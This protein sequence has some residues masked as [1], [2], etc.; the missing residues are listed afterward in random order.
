MR[1]QTWNQNQIS[2]KLILILFAFFSGCSPGSPTLIFSANPTQITRPTSVTPA[3]Q[4]TNPPLESSLTSVNSRNISLDSIHMIDDKQGWAFSQTS[5]LKTWDSGEDWL[6]ITPAEIQTILSTIP[7]QG[8]ST[9][10]IKGSFLSDQNAW[11]AVPGLNQ[12]TIFHTLDG[13]Q[14]WR[15]AKLAVSTPQ[16]I[17][18]IQISSFTFL[19]PQTG[20]LLTSTGMATGHE[21]VELYKTQNGGTTWDF[22]AQ[23]NQNASGESIGSITTI[24]QKTG[25]SFRDPMDGWLTGSTV[26]NVIFFYRTKDS[27]LTWDPQ[28]LFIPNGYTALGGSSSSYP[29]VFFN[30]KVGSL[31]VYLGKATPSINLFFYITI[32][33]GESWTP[34]APLVSQSNSFVWDW[35]DPSHG[36]A[37]IDGS[38]TITITTDGGKSWSEVLVNGAKFHQLDFVSPMIGWA[39]SDK[40]LLQTLDGGEN[41]HTI[42]P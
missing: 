9:F 11:I 33:A 13:G 1:T 24:G 27:G 7:A 23:A 38:N 19:N 16:E 14:T 34:I 15:D 18:P 6:N 10:E 26:G 40:S 35:V 31:P 8:V 12:I 28:Q 29:P 4:R 37:T 17:Y 25:I 30:S 41:W 39:I 32:D 3:T 20:W 22:V 2:L 5:L 42:Y 21:F 36:F